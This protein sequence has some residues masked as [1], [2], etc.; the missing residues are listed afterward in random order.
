MDLENRDYAAELEQYLK[1]R[2][3]T[4]EYSCLI[5]DICVSVWEKGLEVK[6]LTGEKAVTFKPVQFC[7]KREL[8]EKAWANKKKEIFGNLRHCKPQTDP[9]VL[10][11]MEEAAGKKLEEWRKGHPFNA[12]MKGFLSSDAAA[13]YFSRGDLLKLCFLEENEE[14]TLARCV[15]G[16]DHLTVSFREIPLQAVYDFAS[17]KIRVYMTGVSPLYRQLAALWKD[18][19]V[20][21]A[22]ETYL[23]EKGWRGSVR[24]RKKPCAFTVCFL[25]D[26]EIV[27]EEITVRESYRRI[28]SAAHRRAQ[29]RAEERKK[30]KKE[31]LKKNP[32]HGSCLAQAVMETIMDR[33][34][35]VT[36]RQI[37]HILRGTNLDKGT[38]AA[39]HAGRYSLL[40]PEEISAVING[41]EGCG[42][43]RSRYVH[44][45]YQN[46]YIY[47]L[48][49][50]GYLL[51]EMMRGSCL[52][53]NPVTE[54]EYLL[55]MRAVR[56]NAK[57][58]QEKRKK[59]I[60]K[61]LAENPAVFLTDP[62]VV[63]DCMEGMGEAAAAFLK[64]CLEKEESK[65]KKRIL[66]L[67]WNAA[68]GK[69]KVL[70]KKAGLTEFL[71]REREKERKKE[72]A[73]RKDRELLGNVLTEIPSRYPDLYPAARRMKRHFILHIGPTNSGKTHEAVED[74]MKAENGIYLGP[75]RLLAAEMFERMNREGCSCS[76][77]T[78]EE[79]C[80]VEGAAHQSSTIEMADLRKWYHTAVID[81]AQMISDPDRGGAW[82]AAIM[83]LCASRIHVCTA[84]EGEGCL[85]K[86]IEECGDDFEIIRHSRMTPLVFEEKAFRFP[87]DVR[88]GDALIVF[89][90]M[91]VHT[92]AAQLKK[93]KVECS[94]IYG[95]LPYDVRLDQ[96]ERFCK[97]EAK[98][99]VATDAIGMGMNLPIRRV[100][101]LETEK[102]DGVC[103]RNLTEQ[104]I[105]Q[106]TGRAGRYGIY[107]AGYA[108]AAED[109][110]M[111]KKALEKTAAYAL[112]PVIGF[113]ETI[114][115]VDASI[116]DLIRK[117]K[118]IN[119]LNGWKKA[120]T[121]RMYALAEMTEKLKAKR[122]LAY[123]FLTVPFD[124][125]NGELLQIWLSVFA[126]EVRRKSYSI[127]G[128]AE[129]RPDVVPSGGYALSELEQEYRVL[130]LYYHLARKFQPMEGTLSLITEKRRKCSEA[131]MRALDERAYQTRRCR[132]CGR[133][134]PWDHQ[135]GLCQSCYQNRYRGFRDDR[136]DWDDWDNWDD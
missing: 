66:K 80:Q 1:E 13:A 18:H 69:G 134:L 86:I 19:P 33:K 76:L 8:S 133:E 74:L 88:D 128:M 47:R 78:G 6:F 120:S 68:A 121:E 83:G 67:L 82:A 60:L 52:K 118:E 53:N 50:D 87:E 51:D 34:G 59:D 85:T 42:L 62:E 65:K 72:E 91:K 61:L 63:L 49:P 114:L 122:D 29:K 126:K 17:G 12:Q 130:D 73:E 36:A 107:D 70:P 14:L 103:R 54:Q 46:Y 39:R 113:P 102:F 2:T 119:P 136:D 104:E 71:A 57:D 111:V 27:E 110:E 40:K 23:Q 106:I 105:R 28:V 7:I 77:V 9:A 10:K 124:E 135:Y 112:Q 37:V 32:F 95:A 4:F 132:S 108:A 26:R 94:I 75:L 3:G 11:E 55:Y 84:P 41:L 109:R 117:W 127:C 15:A 99:V 48:N 58:I 101:L 43:I 79:E 97:E 35:Y 100:V 44:G 25:F 21:K 131:I 129:D 5:R 123:A 22:I 45:E 125:K 96:A 90:R 81:E 93:R 64:S 30:E 89:S 92:V 16:K 56:D 24:Y 116:L 115:S 31:Q 98:V 20:K 38:A